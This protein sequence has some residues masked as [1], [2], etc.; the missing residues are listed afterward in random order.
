MVAMTAA[1][2]GRLW[3]LL[4][5]AGLTLVALTVLPASP[6]SAHAVLVSS[7]PRANA[8][9]PSAPAEVVLTFSEGVREVPDRIRVIGPDG[10]RVDRGGPRFDGGV[11][12]IAV[13]QGGARG[14]YLVSYRVISADS[15]PVSG[16]Y[17]YAV[18]APSTTPSD[19]GARIDPAVTAAVEVARYIGYVGLLLLT[20]PAL[21]LGLLWPRRLSR[22]GPSRLLWTGAGL[23][24]AA[25]V[26]DVWLQ[27]PFVQGGGLFDVD[28][29]GLRDVLNSGYGATHLV[30]L[31]VL[32][33][34]AFLLRTLTIGQQGRSDHVLLAILGLTGLLTWP[35][36]GHPTVSPIPVVSMVADTAH[37]AAMAVWLGG[38]VVL[39][40][41]LLRL[42][43]DRELGA[44]LPVWSRWATFSVCTLLL[45]GTVQAL[46][47][48]G[49]LDG[50][51]GTRYGQ[52]VIAKVV[53]FA[54][55]VSA[56]A[57]ARQLVR[58]RAG[59]R[60]RGMRPAVWT[61]LGIAAVILAVSAVLVHTPPA[62]TAAGDAQTGAAQYFSTTLSSSIYQLQVEVDPAQVG[63]NTVHLYAY[64]ADNKPLPVVEWRATAALPDQGVEP[65][66]I[67]LLPLTDNHATGEVRLPAAGNWQLRFTVRITEIDQ[68]TVSATVPIT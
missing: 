1:N 55:A 39:A 62:R 36:A 13:D 43:D 57:Y 65:I 28:W 22:R 35:L 47:E 25:T 2:R 66:E 23:L 14:S 24:A 32:A 44:I 16:G 45:A 19:T 4:A 8:V 3:R 10:S 17:T 38:L 29:P 26:A 50:L 5:L 42:A 59:G 56:A 58:R 15:H 48:V 60:S 51:V 18:G 31:G 41:F 9:L 49:S 46:I 33:A 7:S 54:G 21:V 30:R 63:S 37:L 6:A 20:G 67:P 68:A 11:V 52:L 53:L 40:V 61:E 12:T 27:V 34:A 64:T